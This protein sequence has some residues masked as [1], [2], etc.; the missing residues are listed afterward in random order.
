MELLFLPLLPYLAWLLWTALR[1]PIPLSYNWRSLWQRKV[2]T[3]S[4]AGAIAVVVAIFVVVLS[5]AQGIS[6]AFVSSGRADQVV[7]LRPNA[8]VELNSS[9]ERDRARILKSSPLVAWDSLGPLASAECLTVKLLELADGS[10]STNVLFRGLEPAGVRM[11]SQV[12]LVE[13]RWF[14]PNLPELVLPLKMKDRFRDIALGRTFTFNGL[15]WTVVGLFDAGSSA[16]DSEVWTDVETLMHAH[17]RISYNAM[18]VRL[19][20]PE[21]I[22]VFVKAIEDDKRLKLEGKPEAAYFAQQTEAGKPIQILGQMITVIL[23]VGAIFAAMNTMFAA[24]ASR[25]PEIG[26]LRA[27]GFRRV[28]I[29]A[30]FQ[31]EALMLCA[32]GGVA[33]AA[34]ALSFNGIRTGTTNFETFSDVGFAF[35]VT[36]A[37]MLEGFGFSLLMGV[38]GGFP[39][40][41]RASRIPVTDA[42]KGG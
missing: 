25:T 23:T 1:H 34:M 15:N 11:R 30:S 7:V 6:S 16:F 40:A 18:L 37:L 19:Q 42:M 10:G 31:W 21:K 3:L 36:P 39:P 33:G 13:G 4:T 9:L 32:L 41:W 29:L 38:L 17:R 8:R 20:A 5:L 35:T 28:E 2:G 27:L 12:R 14:R 22:P 26:T 24:V